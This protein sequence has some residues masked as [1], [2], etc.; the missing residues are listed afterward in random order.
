MSQPPEMEAGALITIIS[1][2]QRARK[3]GLLVVKRVNKGILEEGA[4][5]FVKGQVTG[6]ETGRRRGQ[7]A[8]NIMSQWKDCRFSFVS[9]GLQDDLSLFPPP[10]PSS[11]PVIQASPSWMPPSS[12]PTSEEMAAAKPDYSLS[13]PAVAIPVQNMPFEPALPKIDQ[14]GSRLY[15]Q[16]FLLLDGRR[17]VAE[18]IRLTGRPPAE[19]DKVLRKLEQAGVIRIVMP[20]GRRV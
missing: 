15:R 7:D 20:G 4:I 16:I 6:S 2:I 19:V 9:P 17:S 3:T 18:L 8:F 13:I 14:L 5:T 11:P 1:R 10:P 12:L